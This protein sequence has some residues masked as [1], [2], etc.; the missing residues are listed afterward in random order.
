VRWG[1]ERSYTT[2]KLP[3]KFAFLGL[4]KELLKNKI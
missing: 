3:E 4:P 2:R 1:D